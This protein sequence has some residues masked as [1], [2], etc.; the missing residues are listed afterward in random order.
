[1]Y[2][3]CPSLSLLLA[4]LPSLSPLS[5]SFMR[6]KGGSQLYTGEY[7]HLVDNVHFIKRNVEGETF[8]VCLCSG[9]KGSEH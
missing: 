7:P 6:S 8:I 5:V 1:M 3:V 9:L 4:Q 2:C